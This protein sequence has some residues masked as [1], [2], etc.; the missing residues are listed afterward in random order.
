MPDDIPTHR[1]RVDAP[2][3]A[4][5]TYTPIP[6]T[7]KESSGKKQPVTNETTKE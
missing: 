5:T 7:P 1:V 4:A 3:P 2:P 6:E